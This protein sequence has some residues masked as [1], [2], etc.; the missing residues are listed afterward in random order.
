METVSLTTLAICLCF[1]FFLGAVTVLVAVALGGYL[2]FRTKKE[3]HESLF[4]R[5]QEAKAFIVDE[6]AGAE[7]INYPRRPA[8]NEAMPAADDPVPSILEKQTNKF[9]HVLKE[10]RQKEGKE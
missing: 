6:F 1:S 4:G 8:F 2:V 7:P 5:T 10:Q 9:L 3:A